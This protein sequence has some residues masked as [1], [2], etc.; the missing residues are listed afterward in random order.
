MDLLGLTTLPSDTIRQQV[1]ALDCKTRENDAW[2]GALWYE[3]ESRPLWRD[4]GYRTFTDCV[5]EEQSRG[6]STVMTCV[7][8][9]RYFVVETGM[10]FEEYIQLVIR[11]GTSKMIFLRQEVTRPG[12][13]PAREATEPD[14]ILVPQEETPALIPISQRI[15]ETA[16]RIEPMSKREARQATSPTHNSPTIYRR[17]HLSPEEDEVLQTALMHVMRRADRQITLDT[18][19]ALLAAEYVSEKVLRGPVVDIRPAA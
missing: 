11:L 9:Y 4:W 5:T 1:V 13:D 19:L 2:T 16:E 18:A 17:Y 10:P 12:E 6:Y 8:N 7:A 3:V 14:L 15:Q